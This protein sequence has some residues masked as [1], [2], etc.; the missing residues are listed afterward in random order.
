MKFA[1]ILCK[2]CLNNKF[3]KERPSDKVFSIGVEASTAEKEMESAVQFVSASTSLDTN[4][5]ISAL[6]SPTSSVSRHSAANDRKKALEALQLKHELVQC[7]EVEAFRNCQGSGKTRVGQ[8]KAW[9]LCC[10][11]KKKTKW[12]CRGCDQENDTKGARRAWYC[13]NPGRSCN[14]KHLQLVESN[15]IASTSL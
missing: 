9:G 14:K 8:R 12:F 11:C 3:D 2:D 10:V 15:F 7:K 5:I 1:S 6:S 13:D 4:S